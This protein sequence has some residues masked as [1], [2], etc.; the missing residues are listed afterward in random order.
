M[1]LSKLLSTFIEEE[2]PVLKDGK[3]VS[4][5][6]DGISLK[7]V[8][9]RGRLKKMRETAPGR[10]GVTFSPSMITYN[11]CR[12]MK[13]AQMAGLATLYYDKAR[14]SDQTV[15]DM[16]NSLHDLVQ[17]YFWDIGILEGNFKCLKC[18]KHYYAVSPTTCPSGIKSHKRL[19]LV[20]KEVQLEK[21][22]IR[23][24]C[25]GILQIEGEKHIMDIKSIQNKTL[26][27][28]DRQFTFEDLDTK[29]PKEAHQVQLMFYM[30]MS[31]IYRGHLLYIAKNNGQIKTFE[32]PYNFD[33]IKPYL[34]EVEYLANTAT[35]LKLG[36]KVQLPAPCGREDCKC[37]EILSIL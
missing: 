28:V 3:I 25:D 31:G 5:K 22:L 36:Y 20:Y 33:L 7:G 4:E 1:S 9:Q 27:T 34:R 13:V 2:K 37:D 14:P 32:I 12:R 18:D 30:W 15:M 26:K 16:G 35:Q 23:G 19:A 11:F 8:L 6:K 29:G 24:R 10:Q 21:D 17:G